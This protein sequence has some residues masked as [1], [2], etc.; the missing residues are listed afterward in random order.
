MASEKMPFLRRTSPERRTGVNPTGTVAMEKRILKKAARGGRWLLPILALLFVSCLGMILEKPLVTLH[1]VTVSP[2]SFT[3]LGLLL[4][5]EVKNPN[6][7]DITLTSFEYTVFLKG[8]PIGAGR[9]EKELLVPAAATTRLQAPVNA[10]FKDMG[11]IFR[12]LLAGGDKPPY[13]F[14]GR[15]TIATFFGSRDFTF[16]REEDSRPK[17]P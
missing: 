3:E 10:N 16:L 11:A 15:A 5:L 17:E 8:E 6:R 4:D 7:F 9:L 14:E 1:K 13:A 12:A 2:R